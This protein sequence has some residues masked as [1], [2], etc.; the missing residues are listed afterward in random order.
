MIAT[1]SIVRTKKR[2][3]EAKYPGNQTLRGITTLRHV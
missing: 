2:Y 1:T 3:I